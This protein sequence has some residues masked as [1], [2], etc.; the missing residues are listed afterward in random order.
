MCVLGMQ[1]SVLYMYAVYDIHVLYLC[2]V[3]TFMHT[4]VC[5][6]KGGKHVLWSSCSMCTYIQLGC[7]G[8][9]GGGGGWVCVPTFCLLSNYCRC[10]PV[11][12]IW[13]LLYILTL[14]HMCVPPLHLFP[15]LPTSSSLLHHYHVHVYHLST[16]LTYLIIT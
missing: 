15:P 13:L 9:G 1:Q 14:V 2:C 7:R 12:L 16:P 10:V 8:G 5:F 6:H 4:C 11:T 3:F